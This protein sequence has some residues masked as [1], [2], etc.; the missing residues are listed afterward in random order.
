MTTTKPPTAKAIFRPLDADLHRL[1]VLV[2]VCCRC[3]CLLS[4]Q[5]TTL[6]HGGVS[7]GLCEECSQAL[8]NEWEQE[9]RP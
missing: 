9:G 5:V 8:W 7:D 1:G 2:G 4:A 3:G 6:N